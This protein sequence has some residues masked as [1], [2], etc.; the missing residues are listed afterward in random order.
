M[1]MVRAA[2]SWNGRVLTT[3][4]TFSAKDRFFVHEVVKDEFVERFA[5]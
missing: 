3:R 4:A 2:P 5:D 1:R